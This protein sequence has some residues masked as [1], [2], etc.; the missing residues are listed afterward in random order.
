[1]WDAFGLSARTWATSKKP[2]P[3]ARRRVH[4]SARFANSGCGGIRAEPNHMDR[5]HCSN[6]EEAYDP[7]RLTP[8]MA[9]LHSDQQ[10][11]LERA[12][13][14][15]GGVSLQVSGIVD[16]GNYAIPKRILTNPPWQHSNKRV[17]ERRV[18]ALSRIAKKVVKR[19]SKKSYSAYKNILQS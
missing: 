4:K 14:E 6:F 12:L 9:T 3:P 11:Y 19:S 15:H 16:R 10:A 5:L 8:Q 17:T 7:H 2:P 18:E 1:M 13:Q